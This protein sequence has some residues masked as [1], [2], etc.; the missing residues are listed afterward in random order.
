MLPV[1]QIPTVD[2]GIFSF[3]DKNL[4]SPIQI[5]SWR[6]WLIRIFPDYVKHPFGERHVKFWEWVENIERDI[7]PRPFVALWP[8]GGSK[9]TS[10]ELACVRLG[11]KRQRSYI[12]YVSS[13][14]DKADKHVE[15]IGS[16]LESGNI[17]D[18][19]PAI[20]Q[21]KVGKYSNSRGWRRNRLR[22]KSGLTI[23]ALGLDV[24]ARGGK[25]E[26]QRPDMIIF[27]DVD[28]KFDTMKTTQ[29]K[30]D[31]ITTTILPAGSADC[32][33]LFVQNLIHEN[34]IAAMLG[35]GRAEFLN[36]RIVSGVYPAVV[37]L[38][39]EMHYEE[40][41][42][43]NRYTIT[44][45]QPTWEG[46]SL[47]TCESQ[48]NEWGLSAFLQEAQHDVALKGGYWDHIEFRHCEQNEVP[49][50]VRGCVWCD[51]AVTS[52]DE[53]CANGIIA[54][55]IAE[56]GTL[57]RLFSWEQI[58]SP[59]NILK[60]AIKKAIEYHL[61]MVGV[62]TNQGGDLWEDEY[63]SALES[64]QEE[65]KDRRG[66]DEYKRIVF[67]SFASAKAG[68]GS[69]G[70][71]ERN[72]RMLV[73]YEKGRII[74]VIGTHEVLERALQRFPREPLDLADA[75]YW[76]WDCLMGHAGWKDVQDLGKVEEFKSVWG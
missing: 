23:D 70:K 26:N 68:A 44:A 56:N 12:W 61:T 1:I 40:N 27:D 18:Y 54:D 11:Y 22:T 46:Q 60:R 67:P 41:I 17:E 73:D 7:K 47:A 58:D 52:T 6:E 29:R 3:G 72:Q 37:G 63:Q 30:L 10:A 20:A 57:Y 16:M 62:E 74:H 71:V 2:T 39:Y 25:V 36:D 21:R 34:S 5:N 14:Q 43:R 38:A 33:V 31:L 35:D 53:S 42:K 69:G 75:A 51:P 64:V 19:D 32:A 50:L 28:E 13:T 65:I 8:R 9:S 55:G 66:N 24:G 48:I 49:E 4:I 15:T 45:G 59:M 76:G